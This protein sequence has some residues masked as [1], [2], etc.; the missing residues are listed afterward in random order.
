M[1][2]LLSTDGNEDLKHDTVEEITYR[3]GNH[4]VGIEQK[5]NAADAVELPSSTMGVRRKVRRKEDGPLALCCRW[6]AEHQ[7]GI[8]I[9]L[10]IP[11][12]LD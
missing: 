11:V 1:H 9:H 8:W 12:C 4:I 2:K 10:P 5:I 3:N 7:I 6:V